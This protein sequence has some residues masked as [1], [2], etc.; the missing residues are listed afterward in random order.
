MEYVKLTQGFSRFLVCGLVLA[1]AFVLI[2]PASLLA[3]PALGVGMAADTTLTTDLD[4]ALKIIF[5]DPLINN[6][7]EDTELLD[8]FKVDM[9]VMADD[10]TGGRY[11]EMAHYFQLPAGVGARAENEYIPEPDDPRFENS[12]LYLRKIQGTVEMSGDVM[13]RVRSDEGAFLNYMERALPDLVTRLVNEIDRMY[14]S[15]GS[16]IKARIA[17]VTSAVGTTLVAVINR[18]Y[19]IDALSDPFLQFMEGERNVFDP[20]PDGQSLRTGG[21]IQALQLTDIDEDANSMTW[22]GI[23]AMVAVVAADDYIFAG[24]EAGASSETAGGEDR[25]IAGLLAGVDDGGI[26]ATYNNID[27]TAAGNRLWKSI[28][29]D[30]AVAQWG[31]QLTEELLTFADDECTTK[32][33]GKVDTAVMSRAA[34]RGYW[35]SLKGD[36]TMIDPRS[37][38]GGKAGL[39]LILGDRTLA[40]KVSRKMPPELTFLLQADTFRRLTLGTWEWDDRTGSIWNR[41]TDATGRKDAYYAVGNMYEQLFCMAPRKNVRIEGLTAVF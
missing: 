3:G 1:V 33:A 12:R 39:S 32:G 25:E 29:I 41:V 36:R 23:N 14:I 26:I 31:G 40:L 4:E 8:I 22:T 20:A 24:D 7:V 19:G 11:I 2:G 5:S 34:A 35:Q 18:T 38:T 10:T 17:S 6:I 30:S 21:G 15:D 9:N 13:R 28:V 27:R 16:G 37:Y